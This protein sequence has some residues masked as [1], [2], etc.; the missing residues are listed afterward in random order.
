[1]GIYFGCHCFNMTN[2]HASSCVAQ[3]IYADVIRPL[4]WNIQWTSCQKCKVG[5]T[6]P[7]LPS[8][9]SCGL[10]QFK[11][12]CKLG[13]LLLWGKKVTQYLEKNSPPPPNFCR[14]DLKGRK[15]RIS[16]WRQTCGKE[17]VSQ[18]GLAKEKDFQAL[19]DAEF[20][21]WALDRK[22]TMFCLKDLGEQLTNGL[23]LGWTLLCLSVC[24]SVCIYSFGLVYTRDLWLERYYFRVIMTP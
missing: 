2:G 12:D 13:I 5:L 6:R 8:S 21:M 23:C 20:S 9:Y 3:F 22:W 11:A 7:L 18:S 1:M 14:I 16:G 24:L 17:A 10:D 4:K 19:K 15:T